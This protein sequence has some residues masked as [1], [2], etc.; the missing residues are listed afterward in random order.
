MLSV[1]KGGGSRMKNKFRM[2]KRIRKMASEPHAGEKECQ[3]SITQVTKCFNYSMSVWI[4][5]YSHGSLMAATFQIKPALLKRRH[6]LM[7]GG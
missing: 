2:C 6:H 3:V 1:V 4:S 7:T 5:L